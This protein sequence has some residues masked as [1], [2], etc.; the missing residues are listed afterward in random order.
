MRAAGVDDPRDLANAT[1]KSLVKRFLYLQPQVYAWFGVERELEEFVGK[2]GV[3][4]DG[5]R[6]H[7]AR[8]RKDNF[9]AKASQGRRLQKSERGVATVQKPLEAVY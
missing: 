1:K 9:V 4:L 5:F 6:R 3:G 7:G 2:A 8:K